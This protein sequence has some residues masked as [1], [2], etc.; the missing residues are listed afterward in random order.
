MKKTE[1]QEKVLLK[2]LQLKGSASLQEIMKK[3]SLSESTTRRLFA[4]MEKKGLAIRSHG[5]I[6]LPNGI[7]NY[8]NYSTAKD[9]YIEE[10]RSIAK[11]AIKMIR[12]GDTIFLDSGSTVFLFSLALNEALKEGK[13][14]NIKV[15]TNS[16]MVLDNLNQN[17]NVNLLGGEYRSHR[18]DFCGYITEK[19]IKEFHYSKCIMGTDGFSEEHGFTTTDFN[20][21]RICETAISKSDAV[22][23]LMDSHKFDITSAIS[24]SNGTDIS[25]VVVDEKISERDKKRL[26]SKGLTVIIA[27]ND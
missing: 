5:I 7:H 3:C 1:N 21:A 27:N 25:A 2:E 10:K 9:M 26:M 14:K 12:D 17:V 15:F 6:S 23:I 13:L 19:T 8:Y 20:T 4:R 11:E 16:F 24:Y 22:I 18:K